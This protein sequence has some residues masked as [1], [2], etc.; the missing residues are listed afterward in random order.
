MLKKTQNID[1]V[2]E[3]KRIV[4]KKPDKFVEDLSGC[5]NF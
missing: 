1:Y 3:N 4:I 5:C 2:I